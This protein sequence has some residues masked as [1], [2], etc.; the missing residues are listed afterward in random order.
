MTFYDICHSELALPTLDDD[1]LSSLNSF[2][3]SSNAMGALVSPGSI[4]IFDLRYGLHIFVL[5]QALT[6]ILKRAPGK[7]DCQR[8]AFAFKR[9]LL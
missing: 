6:V 2:A 9:Q 8:K 5:E 7:K 4:H 1:A 3:V